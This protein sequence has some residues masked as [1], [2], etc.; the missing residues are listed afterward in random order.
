MSIFFQTKKQEK[1]TNLKM[2]QVIAIANQ[3]GGVAKTNTTFHLAGALVE[4]GYKILL[5]DAD[6]QG[7]LSATLLNNIYKLPKTLSN[8]LLDGTDT[9]EIIHKTPFDNLHILPANPTLSSIDLQLSSEPDAHYLLADKLENIKNNYH[10]IIIDCPP[11]L[12]LAT[13]MAL[14]AA[15][16][17]IIPIEC[18]EYAIMGSKQLLTAINKIRRRMNPTLDILGYL[19]VKYNKRT[20]LE[21]Q[22]LKT[23]RDIYKDEVFKTI[24]HRSIK[25]AEALELGKPITC[26][27]PHSKY[28]QAYRKLAEEIINHA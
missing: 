19:V 23:F 8:L 9:Q 21:S 15:E 16:K 24:I 25:Y 13:R 27:L 4:R 18:Q 7:N 20:K 5:V 3:K 1:P 11:S 28:A 22:Y 14:V 6:Q 10:Y 17:V 26:F 12:G 2:G